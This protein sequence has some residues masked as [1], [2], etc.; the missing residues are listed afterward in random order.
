M[1]DQYFIN[2]SIRMIKL[3]A[4]F[5]LAFNQPKQ[6]KKILENALGNYPKNMYLLSTL[7]V[8]YRANGNWN[9]F[10][11]TYDLVV[12][13]EPNN[14]TTRINFSVALMYVSNYRYAIT[15]LRYCLD[16]WTFSDFN[17][18]YL[19]NAKALLGICY[20]YVQELELA[21]SSLTEAQKLNPWNPDVVFGL[22]LYF[23]ATGCVHEIP[24]FLE[25]KINI[26][27]KIYAFY[28]WRA[29][30]TRYYLYDL[31]ESIKWYKL[32]IDMI[33]ANRFRKYF[34][35]YYSTK[36]EAIPEY[37]LREYIQALVSLGNTKQVAAAIIWNKIKFPDNSLDT[38]ILQIV[39]EI[40]TGELKKAEKQCLRK[41]SN[42]LAGDSLAEYWS[43]L[44]IIQTKQKKFDDGINSINQCLS[45]AP[46]FSIFW[47]ILGFLQIEKR[48]WQ[49]AINTFSKIIELDC[50]D[51]D[52]WE[53]LG[54][55]QVNIGN[56]EAASSAYQR[57]VFIDPFDALAWIDLGIIY[58]QLGEHVLSYS[59]CERGLSYN[60]VSGEREQLA[61]SI[62]KNRLS[63]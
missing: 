44:A 32:A 15:Q 41:L 9:A 33:D 8:A 49:N 57:T 22:L 34:R 25:R 39:F 20:I 28:Y 36:N 18:N 40:S 37:I 3:K 53:D 38:T 54:R 30:I 43:L 4:N 47:K 11:E 7:Q 61:L 52:A 13:L 46:Y 27:P 26:Y 14:L 59:A 5:L 12:S 60:R 35:I 2:F 31:T 42:N 50:L 45:I 17:S 56:L 10:F 55:C 62:I 51:S 19:A 16:H 23:R 29:F 58:Y 21:E 6:A 48:E 1:N 63:R 24:E